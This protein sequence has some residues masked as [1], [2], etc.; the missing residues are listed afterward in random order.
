MGDIYIIHS[1]YWTTGVVLP[2]ALTLGAVGPLVHAQEKTVFL[3]QECELTPEASLGVII[4]GELGLFQGKE[5]FGVKDSQQDVTHKNVSGVEP[6][7]SGIMLFITAQCQQLSEGILV[8]QVIQVVKLDNVSV[9]LQQVV[10]YFQLFHG[11]IV[12]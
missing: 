12:G 6:A 9:Y 11:F 2:E 7:V 1:I 4:Y 8:Q 10:K 5:G 3:L